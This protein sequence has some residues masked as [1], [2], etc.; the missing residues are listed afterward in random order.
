MHS[1]FHGDFVRRLISLDGFQCHLRLQFHA[2]S[3]A[4][5]CHRFSPCG[6][7]LD[8]AIFSYLPVQETGSIIRYRLLKPELEQ[9][10][11]FEVNRILEE[12]RIPGDAK[13]NLRRFVESEL[14][15]KAIAA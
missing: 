11:L 7:S 9:N 1:I 14:R 15:N 6:A 8:T 12:K 10:W 2:V 4:L 13:E 5:S 3:F